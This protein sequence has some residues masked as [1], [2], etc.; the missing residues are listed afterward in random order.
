M[1]TKYLARS[2]PTQPSCFHTYNFSM[3]DYPI[4]PYLSITS[5]RLWTRISHSSWIQFWR[6]STPSHSARWEE[7]IPPKNARILQLLSHQ[8]SAAKYPVRPQFYW[9]GRGSQNVPTIPHMNGNSLTT[10]HVDRRTFWEY[11][12]GITASG[13]IAI[14]QPWITHS[15]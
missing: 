12:R 10:M 6:S 8:N 4:S 15:E 13:I 3:W 11:K 5:T 14:F 1:A 9:A 2:N 7:F